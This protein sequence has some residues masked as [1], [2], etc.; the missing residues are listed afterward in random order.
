MKQIR[1]LLTVLALGLM[2]GACASTGPAG[3]GNPLEWINPSTAGQCNQAWV[4]LQ[5]CKD[6][7]LEDGKGAVLEKI[8]TPLLAP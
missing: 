5:E 1:T 7:A 6:R 4:E 3:E 8:L 2:L